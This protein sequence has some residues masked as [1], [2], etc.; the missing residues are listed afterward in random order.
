MVDIN[1]QTEFLLTYHQA[2]GTIADLNKRFRV[3]TGG[4]PIRSADGTTVTGSPDFQSGA[5]LIIPKAPDTAKFANA[6]WPPV[7]ATAGETLAALVKRVQAEGEHVGE[8]FHPD[9]SDTLVYI[10]LD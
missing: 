7:S 8:V 1:N 9:D 5:E 10:W 6:T 3:L 2:D 4:T